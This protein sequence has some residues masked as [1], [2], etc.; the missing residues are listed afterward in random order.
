MTEATKQKLADKNKKLTDMVIERAKRDFPED[1]ALIG[2]TGSFAT[3]DFH[4]KS[5]LDWI[6][7]N[8]TDRG[9]QISSAFILDDVGYDV[10]CTSWSNLEKKA[11][12]DCVGV[13]TLTDLQVL[14]CAKPEY[15][16]RLNALKEKARQ[17]LAEGITA[18][19]IR[20]A[21]KHIDL[22]KQEFSNMHLAYGI[23]AIHYAAA[24]L[25]YHL[26]NAVVALNNTCIK[27][28]IKRYMEELRTYTY[29]PRDFEE[30][31]MAIIE[32]EIDEDMM[33]LS[34]SLLS[35]TVSLRNEL[36]EKY[37]AK[38]IP[39]FDNLKGWYEE[40]WCNCRNK[41]I[42]SIDANDKSYVFLAATGAQDYFN[43]MTER[44]GTKKHDLMK[45]FNH[46]NFQPLLNEFMKGMDEC[47]H[48][49][50]SVGRKVQKFDSFDELY[51]TYMKEKK[52]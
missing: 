41:M 32:S 52:E 1:I 5:D 14:Y 15:L 46:K 34:K 13:S 35:V 43:E 10:Y 7:V 25:A 26:I 2:L 40:C 50:E 27:R 9:W 49:Y 36:H 38:P 3:G 16:D 17:K 45:H 11:E 24:S 22:A 6:I 18:D 20:R 31:Y 28:G 4:E 23:G 33:L 12:L 47:L 51:A 48:E 29:L 37:V 21:N 30:L 19:S 42:A 8:N 44:L 39:T